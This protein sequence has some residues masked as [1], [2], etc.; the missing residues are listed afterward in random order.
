MYR[1]ILLSVSDYTPKDDTYWIIT[2]DDKYHVSCS[3]DYIEE[4]ISIETYVAYFYFLQMEIS[5][6]VTRDPTWIGL[7][8]DVRS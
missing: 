8:F 1:T 7:R 2:R 4:H 5:F 3:N 6:F